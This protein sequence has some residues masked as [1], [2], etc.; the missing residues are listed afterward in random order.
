MNLRLELDC[1]MTNAR[2]ARKAIPKPLVLKTWQGVLERQDTL[3]EDWTGEP[4]VLV[5]VG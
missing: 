5:G 4:Q 1:Q 2:W 3:P